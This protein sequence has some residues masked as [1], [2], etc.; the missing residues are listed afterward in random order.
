MFSITPNWKLTQ[1]GGERCFPRFAVWYVIQICFVFCYIAMEPG[2]AQPGA[3][4]QHQEG[5][6]KE[7][8]TDQ[9]V[10]WKSSPCHLWT[11]RCEAALPGLWAL[12]L[13]SSCER[14]PRGLG[15]RKPNKTGKETTWPLWCFVSFF[16]PVPG[17]FSQ[18]VSAAV[19][20][21]PAF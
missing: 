6:D 4:Q 8:H 15:T 1:T 9:K 16:Y 17:P 10:G 13:Q 3:S 2:A 18:A 14:P 21:D 20:R 5:R 7:C 11:P 19:L 12:G